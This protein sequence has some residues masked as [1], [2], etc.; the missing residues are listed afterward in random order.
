MEKKIFKIMIIII[1]LVILLVLIMFSMNKYVFHRNEKK[2]EK[3]VEVKA[4]G[5]INEV[6]DIE[7]YLTVSDCVNNYLLYVSENDNKSIFE[8]LNKS[9]TKENNINEDNVLNKIDKINEKVEFNIK[10]IYELDIDV[11]IK[12]YFIYGY[13]INE[14]D[15]Y[16]DYNVVLNIDYSNNTF[17]IAPYGK[18]Y[19]EY[20]NYQSNNVSIK[21][22]ENL[23]KLVDNIDI[24]DVNLIQ[25]INI[26]DE[27][28]SEFYFK[29]YV[30]KLL[31]NS[32]EAYLYLDQSY[33]QKRFGDFE[34]FQQ[35]IIENNSYIKNG[36]LNKYK[37]NNYGDYDEY[38]CLDNYGN[39]YIFKVTS[40][41]SYTV[42]LDT[43]TIERDEFLKKYNSADN[44][45]RVAMNIEK[46]FSMLNARDYK[47]AYSKLDEGFKQ[48][49]FKTEEDFKDYVKDNF[50]E[51]N[52]ETYSNCKSVNDVYTI[53]VLITDYTM[54]GY[55]GEYRKEVNKTFIMK[56]ED[57]T[58]FVMSFNV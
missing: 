33:S 41:M 10:N 27:S 47:S 57:G 7:T 2:L 16:E 31:Y 11:S 43:Y 13:L 48:R 58:D 37:V 36:I 49:Y 14:Q 39:Y 21:K 38:I 26:N 28:I 22:Q 15:K 6:K 40:P 3:N 52:N 8:L 24:G 51:I 42:M 54:R 46:F 5:E 35:Y 34:E 19:V 32:Q 4:S 45:T 55:I 1:I 50:F 53:D 56:L 18:I 44:E 30:Q 23:K 12:I 20:I 17:S 25:R 29:Q 9:Y